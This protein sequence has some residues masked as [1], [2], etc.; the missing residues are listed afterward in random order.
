MAGY[1][2]DCALGKRSP[3]VKLEDSDAGVLLSVFFFFL[4][5]TR[6]FI[7]QSIGIRHR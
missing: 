4:T 5:V 1:G 7:W 6:L 2:L 3:L